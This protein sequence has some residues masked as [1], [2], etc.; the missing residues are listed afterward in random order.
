MRSRF[1]MPSVTPS[2]QKLSHSAP[3]VRAAVGTMR[4][5]SSEL[6]APVN[7]PYRQPGSWQEETGFEQLGGILKS[8]RL[9][10]ECAGGTVLDGK[11]MLAAGAFP[12]RRLELGRDSV[13]MG[14]GFQ[15]ALRCSVC[16][17]ARG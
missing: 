12:I 1:R 7:W 6:P 8:F 9:Y 17:W 13:A 10:R 5:R 3:L 2:S 14:I 16:S 11:L 4:G 15:F